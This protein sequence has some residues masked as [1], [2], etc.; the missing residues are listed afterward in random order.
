[1]ITEDRGF[2]DER[3]LFQRIEVDLPARITDLTS[4]RVIKVKARDVS[5][6]G[7]GM[8]TKERLDKSAAVKVSLSI[9]DR[10]RRPLISYGTIAWIKPE[11]RWTWRFGVS[12]DKPQFIGLSPLLRS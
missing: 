10:K 3:R 11:T 4:G 5:A 9:P 6:Q 8:L 12:L 7:V 1:M 2:K